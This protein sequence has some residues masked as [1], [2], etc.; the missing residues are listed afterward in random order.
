MLEKK[1]LRSIHV[2]EKENVFSTISI[3]EKNIAKKIALRT[4]I[5]FFQRDP[6]LSLV[7]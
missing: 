7:F 4:D 1:V 5:T 3:L 6:L 2:K